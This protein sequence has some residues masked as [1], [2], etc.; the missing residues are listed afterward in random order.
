MQAT[1]AVFSTPTGKL[2]GIQNI[3]RPDQLTGAIAHALDAEL[4]LDVQA[5]DPQQTSAVYRRV[6]SLGRYR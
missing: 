5:Y 2:V 6:H 4:A 1:V 3:D